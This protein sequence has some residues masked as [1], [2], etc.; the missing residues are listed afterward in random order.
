MARAA[1]SILVYITWL[2]FLPFVACITAPSCYSTNGSLQGSDSQPCNHNLSSTTHSACCNSALGDI[3]LS[4]GL[5]IST[6]PNPNNRLLWASGCTDQT[7]K[8]QSCQQYCTGRVAQVYALQPCPNGGWCCYDGDTYTTDC[9]NNTSNT[10]QLIPGTVIN[11]SA[12]ISSQSASSPPQPLSCPKDRSIIV[13]AC[14][15]A[16][17]GTVLLAS[18]GATV[19]LLGRLRARGQPAPYV[20]GA[21]DDKGVQLLNRIELDGS[22][23]IRLELD[24]RQANIT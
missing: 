5:C 21:T 7:G 15:G 22:Q 11:Q 1:L 23:P 18:L 10:F 3:C 9:C 8:D 24:G 16:I 20:A 12:V 13:G 2:V 14:I 17:L 4:S 6:N 19:F